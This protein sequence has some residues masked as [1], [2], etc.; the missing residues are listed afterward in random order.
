MKPIVGCRSDRLPIV[1]SFDSSS[2]KMLIAPELPLIS[3]RKIRLPIR[4]QAGAPGAERWQHR[5]GRMK[6][7]PMAPSHRH[8]IP[9]PSQRRVR[10]RP[11]FFNQVPVSH[12]QLAASFSDAALPIGP[13][14]QSSRMLCA[15]SRPHL[16]NPRSLELIEADA[17]VDVVAV[18]A[19]VVGCDA[20]DPFGSDSCPGAPLD[21]ADIAAAAAAAATA[22]APP[23]R[24]WPHPATKRRCR[25]SALIR[26]LLGILEHP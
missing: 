14:V 5:A 15:S 24:P 8:P 11:H 17:V 20:G 22:A 3:A 23:P 25:I 16:L 1:K 21:G 4:R 26:S 18:V 2:V 9:S 12:W 7:R 10:V 19:A 6:Q 13:G